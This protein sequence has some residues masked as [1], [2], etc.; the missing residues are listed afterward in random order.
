MFSW[1]GPLSPQFGRATSPLCGSGR[2]VFLKIQIPLMNSLKKTARRVCYNIFLFVSLK[3][4]VKRPQCI[5]LAA[6]QLM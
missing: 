5:F 6:L 4:N 1:K 3:V 2:W